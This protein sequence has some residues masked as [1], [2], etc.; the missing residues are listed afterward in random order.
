[1]RVGAE[2]VSRKYVKRGH[3]GE[4][5]T[6]LFRELR[7]AELL[8]E[9]GD[10]KAAER[11][12]EITNQIATAYQAEIEDVVFRFPVREQD[13]ARD[14]AWAVFLQKIRGYDP[15]TGSRF[16]AFLNFVF[17]AGTVRMYLENH[18]R[19]IALRDLREHRTKGSLGRRFQQELVDHNIQVIEF[20]EAL[21]QMI[22]RLDIQ[23]QMEI[24]LRLE[25][26]LTHKEIAK[27]LGFR[28]R[29]RVQQIEDKAIERL[30]IFVRQ[31]EALAA[32]IHSE[33]DLKA[34]LS[35][36]PKEE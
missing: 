6:A 13:E 36:L 35:M 7:Q 3:E 4:R 14:A 12:G 32:F 29:Q 33:E 17:H 8:A 22:S 23:E 1:M 34:A 31:N 25:D 21:R 11:A 19:Q 2:E 16:Q 27:L 20:Q 15:N 9:A 30:L 10:A 28:S 18:R 26:G 5:E 24:S